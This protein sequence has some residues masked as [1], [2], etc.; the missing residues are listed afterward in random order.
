MKKVLIVTALFTIAVI[1][2]SCYANVS[3]PVVGIIYT[4][5]KYPVAVTSNSNSTK[6][7]SSKATSILGFVAIGDASIDKAAKNA[8]ITKIHHVDAHSTNVLGIF[9]NYEILV[10]GE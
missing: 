8:G 10:Y 6:V 1:L 4:D 5:V 9:A 3:S 7:G 2:T